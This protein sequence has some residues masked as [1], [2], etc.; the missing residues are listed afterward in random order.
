M[1]RLS[2]EQ[3]QAKAPTSMRSVKE[4]K[5]GELKINVDNLAQ[6]LIHLSKSVYI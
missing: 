6:S 2:C 1:L 3:L 4:Q 5:A